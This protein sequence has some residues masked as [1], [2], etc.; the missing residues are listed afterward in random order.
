[1]GFRPEVKGTLKTLMGFA[2]D[3]RETSFKKDDTA[4]KL[5]L[6][7]GNDDVTVTAL[8]IIKQTP[9]LLK[10]QGYQNRIV[11]L[12]GSQREAIAREALKLCVRHILPEKTVRIGILRTA[13]DLENPIYME[14]L[15]ILELFYVRLGSFES[16]EIWPFWDELDLTSKA[17]LPVLLFW[18]NYIRPNYQDHHLQ[19]L[20]LLFETS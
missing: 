1:M 13:L 6:E 9:S 11:A 14:A 12:L 7:G 4:L 2:L 8:G 19:V 16:E 3:E 5:F 15:R 20:I 10:I 18:P 17:P